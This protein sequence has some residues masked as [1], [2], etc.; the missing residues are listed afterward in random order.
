MTIVIQTNN[1]ENDLNGKDADLSESKMADLQMNDH[2]LQNSWE[3][4]YYK[5]PIRG[6]VAAN[7]EH[8]G[9]KTEKEEGT[10]QS[11]EN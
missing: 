10:K 5:R 7:S 9:D 1:H 8:N 3:F 2:K 6:S 11:K 4:W